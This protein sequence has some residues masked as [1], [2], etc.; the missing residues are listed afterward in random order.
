MEQQLLEVLIKL[1]TKLDNLEK[2]MLCM[3]DEIKDIKQ[4]MKDRFDVT[5]MKLNVIENK[6]TQV[7]R[8]LDTTTDQVAR[9]IE[10]IE[11]VK[12]RLQ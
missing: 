1:D 6:V 10:T 4:D 5:D 7:S 12:M 2:N 9:N 3:Q 8:K 11:E